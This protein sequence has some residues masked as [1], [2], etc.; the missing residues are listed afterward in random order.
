MYTIETKVKLSDSD[1]DLV[2]KVT[3]PQVIRTWIVE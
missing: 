2:V 3:R 1:P